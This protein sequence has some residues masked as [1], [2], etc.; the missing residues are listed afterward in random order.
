MSVL[1]VTAH[2]D[3]RS[4]THALGARFAAGLEEAGIAVDRL[5]LYEQQ[6]QPVLSA[7]EIALWAQGERPAEVVEQQRRV[8][9][10]QGLALVY[11]VWWAAPPAILQGWLQR[12]FTEGF[13]Y[14]YQEKA[15]GLMPHPVQL[16]VN[17]G[18]R[19]ET[20]RAVYVEPILGVLRYCGF[21]PTDA[22]VNWG[23]HPHAPPERI[24]GALQGAYEA[25]GT[26]AGH[27]RLSKDRGF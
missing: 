27:Y 25:A 13:A 7:G 16:I 6:F 24:A 12:V 2:P 5:D 20:L 21:G 15:Q 14:R 4:L 22:L 8:G 11:P 17:A 19:D 1:V 26:F 3:R 23:I 18:T 10:A 9:V